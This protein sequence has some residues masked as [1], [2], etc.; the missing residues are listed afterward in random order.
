MNLELEIEEKKNK[1][2]HKLIKKSYVK[3]NTF[4]KEDFN[5][6]SLVANNT[7]LSLYRFS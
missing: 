6:Q 1:N 3:A 5:R 2:T 7:L 4:K